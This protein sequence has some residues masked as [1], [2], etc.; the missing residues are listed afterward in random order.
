ML[1]AILTFYCKNRSRLKDSTHCTCNTVSPLI[2]KHQFHQ[3]SWIFKVNQM[4]S[5]KKCCIHCLGSIKALQGFTQGCISSIFTPKGV[6]KKTLRQS[7]YSL[8]WIWIMNSELTKF[9][10]HCQTWISCTTL[11][12]N[13]QPIFFRFMKIGSP[14]H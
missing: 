3:F 4:F 10:Y 2:A 8:D 14:K 6:R 7:L 12:H 1:G 9:F 5:S 13:L 11:I